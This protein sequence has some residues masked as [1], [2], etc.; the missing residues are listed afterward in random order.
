MTV[1]AI[2]QARM[3]ST[4]L[5]GKSLVLLDGKPVL[6]WVLDH[7]EAIP[8]V[9]RVV[10]A[11]TTCR[12]D[13]VIAD[14]C[15]RRD[16]WAFRGSE[17]DVLNRYYRCASEFQADSVVR[18]TGD[19]PFLN[20]VASGDVLNVFR[21]GDYDYAS[22]IYP[23]VVPDGFDTEVVSMAAL[24]KCW[25]KAETSFDR[26]HVTTYIVNHPDQFRIGQVAY[27]ARWRF[28]M[29]KMSIDTPGDLAFFTQL[30]KI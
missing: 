15:R 6:G 28:G 3:G 17:N 13:D 27:S 24:E 19:C 30:S 26:E 16:V 7:A 2:I 29:L 5:P 4:R 20:P 14:Y 9:D 12:E 23:R 25:Q 8:G 18:I 1:V 21:E 11:T 22:N 10:V